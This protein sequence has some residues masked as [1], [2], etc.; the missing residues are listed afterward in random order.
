MTPTQRLLAAAARRQFAALVARPE[1]ALDL[2][3]AALLVAAEEQPGLDV[4]QYRARLLEYG[5]QA[6]ARVR[7]LHAELRRPTR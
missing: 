2:A 3:H 4:E 1:A 6:R 5:V 7:T